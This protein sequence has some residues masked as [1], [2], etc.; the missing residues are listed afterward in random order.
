MPATCSWSSAAS[1]RYAPAYGEDSDLAF[2]V[3]RAGGP[4]STSH[5]PGSF[6]KAPRAAAIWRQGKGLSGAECSKLYALALLEGH[7]EPGV[8]VDQTQD[9]DAGLR[10]LVLD[11][12]TPTPDQ[13]AARSRP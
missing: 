1:T 5:W 12:C 13:D 2:R 4:L 7:G 3:R 8:D 6:T 11:H 9:R 10:V